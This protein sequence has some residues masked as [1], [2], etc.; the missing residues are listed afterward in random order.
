MGRRPHWF[1]MARQTFAKA[2]AAAFR[3]RQR[4]A[5][6]ARLRRQNKL[7]WESKFAADYGGSA[8]VLTACIVVFPGGIRVG[9]ASLAGE[10]LFAQNFA[11]EGTIQGLF[12]RVK[13]VPLCGHWGGMCFSRDDGDGLPKTDRVC[14][15]IPPLSL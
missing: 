6:F 5:R 13:A 2:E 11:W 15:L 4:R 14:I 10:P 3:R 7:E 1:Q 12:I 8:V 9:V